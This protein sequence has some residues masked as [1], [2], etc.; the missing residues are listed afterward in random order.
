M[1]VSIYARV[2]T[3]DQTCALQIGEL[4]EYIERRGWE[5]ADIYQDTVSGARASRPGLDQLM[6]DARR[7]RFDV[8]LAWKLDRL[9]RSV[10][11][12]ISTIQE[13]SSLGVRFIA[14]S[15][16]IDTDESNPGSKL[17][18]HILASVAEFE[19]SLIRERVAAGMRVAKKYGTKS[20]KPIGRPKVVFDR[21]AVLQLRQSGASISSIVRATGLSTGTVCR[22]LPVNGTGL[23]KPIVPANSEMAESRCLAQAQ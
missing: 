9:G 12:C 11:H 6:A 3:T 15:Q 5:L 13:L 21:A 1:K 14:V 16:G 19:R 10:V 22:S 23:H 7:R 17:L 2:S 4:K 18:L 8:V 20:G